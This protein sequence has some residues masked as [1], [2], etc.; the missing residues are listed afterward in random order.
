[1]SL[2]RDSAAFRS[3]RI[4]SRGVLQ[5]AHNSA[6][7]RFDSFHGYHILVRGSVGRVMRPHGD[8]AARSCRC[9]YGT[10]GLAQTPAVRSLRLPEVGQI[11]D[12][13]IES[14]LCATRE[15]TLTLSSLP[16]SPLPTAWGE[17]SRKEAR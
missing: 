13:E 12:A 16:F 7:A 10:R 2:L 4:K 3:C 14:Q 5:K 1:V 11:A 6:L 8:R 17:G 9:P 15:K